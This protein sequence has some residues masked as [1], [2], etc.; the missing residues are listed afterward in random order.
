ML[1]LLLL[2]PLL[3]VM[4]LNLPLGRFRSLGFW[5]ALVLSL[6]QAYTV[7]FAPAALSGNHDVLGRLFSLGLATDNLSRVLLLSISIVTFASLL[8]GRQTIR[9]EKQR[10]NFANLVL[11]AMTGMNGTV[12]LT[13][14]FSLYVFLEVSAVASFILIAMKRDLNALEGAFKYIVLSAVATILMLSSLAVLLLIS[15]STSFAAVGSAIKAEGRSPL[16]VFAVAM[17]LCGL[18]IKG[19]LVPFHG[20]LP[21]AYS[22]APPAVSIL[23]A[24]IITKVSGIYALIRLATSVLG[25]SNSIN[26]LLMIVGTI[27]ILVGALAALGQTDLKRMLAYSSISQVGY[28]ILGL[29]CGTDLG[30]AGAIFHLFNHSIFK[31]LLFVNS[32]AIEEQLGTTDM[33][34]MGGLGSRMPVTNVTSLIAFLST[35]GLPPLSGFWSKLM[36][37][38]A[39][40]QSSH[41]GYAVL[42]VLASVLTLAYLLTMQRRVFFGILTDRWANVQEAGFGIT[43]PATVLA[44]ITV[45]VGVAFPLMFNSFLLPV[46]SFL[47]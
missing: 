32:A 14:L 43:L 26:A 36:I 27:S 39:L 5:V 21:G 29:G 19:G 12:L 31:S 4:I 30:I 10:I 17:F 2:L 46:A 41:G 7:L 18:F 11:I 35:A 38:V 37:V 6:V 8:V 25:P 33:S 28:I 24:G 9:E 34:Q 45:G 16:V 20:W 22:A 44:L 42:A 40:W 23:L 13:D 1:S 15:G 3:I 47:K